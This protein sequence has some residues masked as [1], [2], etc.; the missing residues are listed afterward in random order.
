MRICHL[1]KCVSEQ[2]IKY[3][4][5]TKLYH[6]YIINSIFV[7]CKVKEDHVSSPLIDVIIFSTHEVAHAS[8]TLPKLAHLA[9]FASSN[10]GGEEK[11]AL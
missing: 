7:N 4:K 6:V 9:K 1:L 2:K 5:I 8:M 10:Y 11:G 3:K